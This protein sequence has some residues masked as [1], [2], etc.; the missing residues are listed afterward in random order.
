MT[1]AEHAINLFAAARAALAARPSPRPVRR[2]L[3]V[4][5][6]AV[7]DTIFFLPVLEA[8]RKGYPAARIVWLSNP[9]PVADELIPATKLVDEVWRWEARGKDPEGRAAVRRRIAEADFDLAVLTLGAPAHEFLA[10]LA[11]VP[12]VA[13]HLRPWRGAKGFVALGDYARAAAINRP[14]PVVLGEHSLARNLRLLRA[15]EVAVPADAPRPALPIPSAARARAA[16]MLANLPA[17]L[18]ALHLGPKDNQYG[19]MWAPDR[20][21][22]LSGRLATAWGGS[23]LLIGSAEE[24]EA[25]SLF[26]A[27]GGRAARSMVGATGL[28]ETFAVLERCALLISNDTGPAKAAAALGVPTATLWGPSSPEEFRSPWDPERHLDVRTGVRCSPCSW[29][30]MSSRPYNYS[31]CGA[32]ECLAKLDVEATAAAVL[33]RWPRLGQ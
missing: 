26:R 10:V 3:V 7:G 17:P 6:G 30:G 4:G 23:F 13:G 21:A 20:F 18:V 25:E 1:P 22:S 2:V 5:Y 9:A 27:A 12:I 11:D 8:L 31:N 14:A 32:R 15:L 33:G 16:D 19:K 28:L 29:M 24:K